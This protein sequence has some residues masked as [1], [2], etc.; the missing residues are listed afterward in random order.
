MTRST[1]EQLTLPS[2]SRRARSCGSAAQSDQ[3][4]GEGRLLPPCILPMLQGP[5]FCI[6]CIAFS[7]FRQQRRDQGAGA[8]EIGARLKVAGER[9]RPR[10]AVSIHNACALWSREPS[11]PRS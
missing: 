7:A 9:Q 1:V 4:G 8:R 6:V 2:W 10:P 5:W 11:A 3:L